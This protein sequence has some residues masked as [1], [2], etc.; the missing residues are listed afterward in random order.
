MSIGASLGIYEGNYGTLN[1]DDFSR[2]YPS[3]ISFYPLSGTD[4][5]F[6]NLALRNSLQNVLTEGRDY[7]QLK[8]AIAGTNTNGNPD[9]FVIYTTDVG[10]EVAYRD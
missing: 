1:Y 9:G 5:S 2:V 10:L 3:L 7:F 4:F 8:L 6:S